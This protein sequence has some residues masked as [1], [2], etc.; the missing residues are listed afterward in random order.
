MATFSGN[1]STIILRQK[2]DGYDREISMDRDMLKVFSLIDGKRNLADI[3]SQTGISIETSL[4]AA[5]RLLDAEVLEI[6]EDDKDAGSSDFMNFLEENLSLA[7]GP[8]AS[9]IIEDEI[10]IMEESWSSFPMD[11]A[12][13]LVNLIARQIPRE[14]KRVVFQQAMIQFLKDMAH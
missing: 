5:K 13:E 1:P 14:E 8:I 6:I 11:R 7:I 12:P 4:N 10:E 9:V 2:D 3:A